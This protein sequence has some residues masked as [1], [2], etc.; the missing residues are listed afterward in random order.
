MSP[1]DV[2]AATAAMGGS[3]GPMRRSGTSEP[4]AEDDFG[5]TSDT[6]RASALAGPTDAFVDAF[7]FGAGSVIGLNSGCLCKPRF[8]RLLVLSIL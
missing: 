6:R 2:A 8:D 7:V 4:P 5:Q 3:V 1:K